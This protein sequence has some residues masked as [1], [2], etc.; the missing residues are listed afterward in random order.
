MERADQPAVYADQRA[1]FTPDRLRMT[2]DVLRPLLLAAAV[3][4][5]ALIAFVLRAAFLNRSFEVFFDE[6]IYLTISQNTAHSYSITYD[7]KIP[8]FLHPPLFFLI[9]AGF[10]DLVR[11]VGN[12]VEQIFA[13]RYLNLLFAGLTAGLILLLCRRLAGWAAGLV[14]AAMFAVEPFLIRI[15]SRNLLET[16]ATFW[17]LLGLYLLSRPRDEDRATWWTLAG[18]LT[19]GAALLTNEPS[20]FLTLLPLAVCTVIGRPLSRRRALLAGFVAV[21]LYS[22]YPLG[23]I[24]S[25]TWTEFFNQKSL[26]IR[27]FI[28]VLQESG[29]NA[30][31]GPSFHSAVIS[32]ADQFLTTYALIG[33][34]SL[35]VL[36]LM[37]FGRGSGRLVALWAGSAYLL[38]AYSVLFGTNE[39]QYFYYVVVFAAIVSVVGTAHLWLDVHER[40]STHNR[41]LRVMALGLL[42]FFFVWAGHVWTERHFTPDDGYQRLL[43]YIELSVPPGSRISVTDSTEIALLRGYPYQLTDAGTPADV[44]TLHVQYVMVST[45]LVDDGYSRATPELVTWLPAHAVLLSRFHGPTDGDLLFY[46][47]SGVP[48]GSQLPALPAPG[49]DLQALGRGPGAPLTTQPSPAATPGGTPIQPSTS[50]TGPGIPGA[51]SAQQRMIQPVQLPAGTSPQSS[52]LSQRPPSAVPVQQTPIS[53]PAPTPVLPPPSTP[54]PPQ[55]P[56]PAPPPS[57]AAPPSPAPTPVPPSAPPKN[58]KSTPTPTPLPSGSP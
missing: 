56:T 25:G 58:G 34:G 21:A 29:F 35:V 31:H 36:L 39:E 9:E 10:L 11:P 49:V 38:Q 23:V 1:L 50:T 19:F 40:A 17:V 12:Q 41:L 26:G 48:S 45:Q 3:M 52:S 15:N 5:V 20:A 42:P 51:G 7:G 30:G 27:R 46:K 44:T 33:Y 47:I 53:A 54:V 55:P 32:H 28:G 16:M 57:T 2:L 14:A 8:F 37:L 43:A 18:G 4:A 24:F 13:V 6:S 22:L